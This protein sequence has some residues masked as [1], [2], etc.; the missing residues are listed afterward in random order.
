MWLESGLGILDVDSFAHE[1]LSEKMP[2][3]A[4]EKG[5]FFP[6]TSNGAMLT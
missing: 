2:P 6:L 4:V 5:V 3:F 1:H